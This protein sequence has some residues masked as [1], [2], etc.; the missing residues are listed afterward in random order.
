MKRC[1]WR[2]W[3]RAASRSISDVRQENAPDGTDVKELKCKEFWR[4][5]EVLDDAPR[6]L[7]RSQSCETREGVRLD[8]REGVVI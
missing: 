3:N 1:N 5:T 6:Y 7:Q 8:R 4:S 2:F